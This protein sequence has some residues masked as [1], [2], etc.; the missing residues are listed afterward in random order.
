MISLATPCLDPAYLDRWFGMPNVFFTLWVPALIL[1][2]AYV[3]IRGLREGRDAWP[4]L[5]ALGMF[6]LSYAGLGISFYPHLVPPSLIIAQAAA[7][8]SSL[9]FLLVGAVALIPMILAY[10][11]YAYRVF[12]GKI[13]PDHGY[14]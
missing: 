10:T 4:F 5:G 7:P 3:F 2:C 14:H 13:D 11:S 6:V 12:R 8:D 9:K 1:V